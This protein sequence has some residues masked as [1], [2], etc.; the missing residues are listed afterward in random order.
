MLQKLWVQVATAKQFLNQFWFAQ[1]LIKQFRI[2]VG[3]IPNKPLQIVD[4]CGV[5]FPHQLIDCRHGFL[6]FQ[7][8]AE[9]FQIDIFVI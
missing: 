7:N 2:H 4:S 3:A 5:A 8:L 9:S 6:V 1:E